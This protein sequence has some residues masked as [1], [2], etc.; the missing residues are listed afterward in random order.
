[1][2]TIKAGDYVHYT[3]P[4]G[5]KENG[6]VKRISDKIAFVVFHCD[7]DWKNYLKYTAASTRLADIHPGWVDEHGKILP[8]YCDHHYIPTNNKWE[9]AIQSE[10][11][12]CGNVIN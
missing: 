7:N 1:M 2:S 6:R 11:I 12:Y 8:E 4:H 3:A 9:S 5:T 10:C